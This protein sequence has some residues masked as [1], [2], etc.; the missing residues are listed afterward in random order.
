MRTRDTTVIARP[1]ARRGW[2]VRRDDARARGAAAARRRRRRV[3]CVHA[4]SH[5]PCRPL[6]LSEPSCGARLKN[7]SRKNPSPS[8][9]HRVS[10]LEPAPRARSIVHLRH[11]LHHCLCS[12]PLRVTR[13]PSRSSV[14]VTICAVSVNNSR[15]CHDMSC[16]GPQAVHNRAAVCT[17]LD[18]ANRARFGPQAVRGATWTDDACIVEFRHMNEHGGSAKRNTNP[19]KHPN[20]NTSSLLP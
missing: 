3:R 1:C 15:M 10:H 13:D 2:R 9:T 12:L 8:R 17:P 16:V 18:V 19:S 20:H 14:S 11:P 5:L 7:S 4:A 6:V